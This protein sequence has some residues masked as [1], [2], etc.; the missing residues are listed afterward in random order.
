MIFLF[1]PTKNVSHTIRKGASGAYLNSKDYQPV[2]LHILIG[3]V[4]GGY[5]VNIF[6]ISPRKHVV[7]TH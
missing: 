1:F 2:K 7:G 5:P 3:L 4:K 6:L